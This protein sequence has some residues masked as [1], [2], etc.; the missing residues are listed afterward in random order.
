MGGDGVMG[1]SLIASAPASMMMAI[2]KAKRDD[3]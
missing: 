3:R 1:N 2:I